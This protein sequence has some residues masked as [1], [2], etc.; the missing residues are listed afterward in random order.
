MGLEQIEGVL[1]ILFNAVSTIAIAVSALWFVNR[2]TLKSN[3][4]INL[5]EKKSSKLDQAGKFEIDL[6]I[7]NIGARAVWIKHAVVALEYRE[8]AELSDGG[9]TSNFETAPQTLLSYQDDFSV[10]P[11]SKVSIRFIASLPTAGHLVIARYFLFPERGHFL[12]PKRGRLRMNDEGDLVKEI[13]RAGDEYYF[14]EY[15]LEV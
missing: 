5:N 7:S 9:I 4:M 10:V 13:E 14:D 1:S 6:E 3:L 11:G 2:G 12:C 8:L 15:V